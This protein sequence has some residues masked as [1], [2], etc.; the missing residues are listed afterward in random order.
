MVPE[1][2]MICKRHIKMQVH[3]SISFPSIHLAI[4]H[5]IVLDIH[6]QLMPIY[7]LLEKLHACTVVINFIEHRACMPAISR[8]A[9]EHNA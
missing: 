6:M 9:D 4:I 2:I 3:L 1:I 8:A 7:D 5:Y